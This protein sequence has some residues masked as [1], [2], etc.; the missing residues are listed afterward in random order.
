MKISDITFNIEVAIFAQCD[1]PDKKLNYTR[2]M[3]LSAAKLNSG[4]PAWIF[5]QIEYNTEYTP[6]IIGM[7]LAFQ[8]IAV[9]D[10]INSLDELEKLFSLE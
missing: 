9:Q 6:Y 4:L 8:I 1:T 7:L 5:N 2:E 10:E 3:V